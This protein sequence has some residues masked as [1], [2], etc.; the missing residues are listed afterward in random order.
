VSEELYGHDV[1]VYTSL[2]YFSA[3][4]QE[5]NTLQLQHS[6]IAKTVAKKLNSFQNC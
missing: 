4:K 2:F 3:R 6:F 1:Y 5:Q